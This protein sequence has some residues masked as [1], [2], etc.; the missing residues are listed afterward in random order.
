MRDTAPA[1]PAPTF[2]APCTIVRGDSETIAATCPR[3]DFRAVAACGG[4]ASPTAVV[5]GA[6]ILIKPPRL[7][8]PFRFCTA[9]RPALRHVSYCFYAVRTEGDTPCALEHRPMHDAAAVS[10]MRIAST[11]SV[12]IKFIDCVRR[13]SSYTLS[14]RRNNRRGAV[15]RPDLRMVLRRRRNGAHSSS[16]PCRDQ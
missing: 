2:H 10:A 15:R 9:D 4:V 6:G 3:R 11:Q 7:H 8:R 13:Q 5:I 16:A 12:T 1:A 14:T